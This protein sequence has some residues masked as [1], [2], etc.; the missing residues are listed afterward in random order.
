MA[1]RKQRQQELSK[2]WISKR[3][4]LRKLCRSA[5]VPV[6]RSFAAAVHA[7]VVDPPAKVPICH[8]P[9]NFNRNPTGVKTREADPTRQS[10]GKIAS[11]AENFAQPETSRVCVECG[12][13]ITESSR[14][15]LPAF[16]I[17]CFDVNVKKNEAWLPKPDEKASEAPAPN[18]VSLCTWWQR[19]Q[20]DRD[21][22]EGCYADVEIN[23]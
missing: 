3:A 5:G 23:G 1:M 16:C 7:G 22:Q 9:A 10:C 19:K 12:A 13:N 21:F 20:K 4:D 2:E 17:H 8:K 14:S 15:C 6:V 11:V 18:K